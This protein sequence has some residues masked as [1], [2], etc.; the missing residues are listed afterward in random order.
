MGLPAPYTNMIPN[1]PKQTTDAW[2]GQARNIIDQQQKIINQF[3]L[4]HDP[5]G[6]TALQLSI[7]GWELADKIRNYL[8]ITYERE[9]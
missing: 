8:V 6:D 5:I 9:E 1:I 4:P 2:L 3:I 7:K